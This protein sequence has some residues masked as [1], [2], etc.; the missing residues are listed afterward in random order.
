MAEGVLNKIILWGLLI[1]FILIFLFAFY[2]KTGFMSKIANLALGAE[3]FLPVE[4]NKEVRQDE[5]LP[6]SVTSAQKVFMQ[7]LTN[8]IDKER[9]LLPFRSLAGL[10]DYKME[11]LNLD[12]KVISTI[13]NPA[14][15]KLNRLSTDKEM[16]LCVADA[17]SFFGCYLAIQERDCSKQLYRDLDSIYITK[18]YLTQ[19]SLFKP[20]KNRACIVPLKIPPSSNMGGCYVYEDALTYDCLEQIKNIPLCSR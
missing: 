2:S 1:L 13:E 5:S 16:Q 4:P 3:R 9:C 14:G 15:I 19:Y 6:Q 20:A 11:V 12:N 18:D 10:E 8:Y 7:D 17:D